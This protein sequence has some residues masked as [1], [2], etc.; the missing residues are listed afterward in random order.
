M[1]KGKNTGRRRRNRNKK[2]DTPLEEPAIIEHPY[3]GLSRTPFTI[4]V[5]TMTTT[6]TP[7]TTISS[8][9]SLC[10]GTSEQPT[11]PSMSSWLSFLES[12]EELLAKHPKAYYK[13]QPRR[14]PLWLPQPSRW[15]PCRTF[16][17]IRDFIPAFVRLLVSEHWVDQ[18]Y[19]L[20]LLVGFLCGCWAA[21][22]GVLHIVKGVAA[23]D[24]GCSVV[25]VT[26]PGPLVTVSLVGQTP[27]NPNHGTYYYSVIHG[28]TRWLDSIAPP[29]QPNSP[30]TPSSGTS[31]MSSGIT[32]PP[33]PGHAPTSPGVPPSPGNPS[34]TRMSLFLDLVLRKHTD[35]HAALPSAVPLPPVP[36]SASDVPSLPVPRKFCSA[37]DILE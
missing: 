31:S 25:Y 27:T 30:N 26:I 17:W 36:S 8:N 23:Q 10:R 29:T 3:L 21:I 20:I 2:I 18:V 6:T 37:K 9:I 15:W 34:A 1:G 24:A 35:R 4:I 12:Q 22:E 14:R 32:T 33:P 28:T 5:T 16:R 19:T 13:Y 11:P 7:A